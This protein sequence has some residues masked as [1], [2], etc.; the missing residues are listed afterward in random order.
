MSIS[1]HPRFHSDAFMNLILPPG[2]RC[3]WWKELS[4]A[5]VLLFVCLSRRT[6]SS[7]LRDARR[8]QPQHQEPDIFRI[9]GDK[10]QNLHSDEP[11]AIIAD[12]GGRGGVKA[13]PKSG[14]SWHAPAKGL[15]EGESLEPEKQ[16]SPQ[17]N[18]PLSLHHESVENIYRSPRLQEWLDRVDSTYS[19]DEVDVETSKALALR[20]LEE[21]SDLNDYERAFHDLA[22][23]YNLTNAHKFPEKALRLTQSMGGETRYPMC[24]VF[25]V[26]GPLRLHCPVVALSL[27]FVTST[28]PSL[29]LFST[30]HDDYFPSFPWRDGD[31]TAVPPPHVLEDIGI[32]PDYIEDKALLDR[33][34]PVYRWCWRQIVNFYGYTHR[35]HDLGLERAQKVE[36]ARRDGFPSPPPSRPL[37]LLPAHPGYGNQRLLW[38]PEEEN[39]VQRPIGQAFTYYPP[40]EGKAEG[41]GGEAELVVVLRGTVF[42][43]EW[44]SNFRLHEASQ[45]VLRAYGM[46][47]AIIPKGFFAMFQALVPQVGEREGVREGGR[48]GGRAS[49]CFRKGWE[50]ARGVCSLVYKECL[51]PGWSRTYL[52]APPPL[53]PPT[54]PPSPPRLI[55]SDQ[56]RPRRSW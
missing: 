1:T 40:S 18:A 50:G 15:G 16:S 2:W 17:E 10:H 6:T 33:E 37:P 42:S 39:R 45:D 5:L 4:W 25:K 8:Q 12:V 43:E 29:R 19:A 56:C 34:R 48:E 26:V 30:E 20:Y 21:R 14:Q 36:E 52:E 7:S 41:T 27:L 22:A 32:V 51:S 3:L 38:L 35:W 9:N 44:S 47:G 23:A 13:V 49:G 24:E 31:R 11:A 54:Q 55:S 28:P 46:E 53:L